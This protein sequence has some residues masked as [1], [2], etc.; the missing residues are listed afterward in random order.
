MEAVPGLP[1]DSQELKAAARLIDTEA[2]EK[3]EIRYRQRLTAVLDA[4]REVSSSL[5]RDVIL[6]NIVKRVRDL[7][8]V[9]EAVLFLAHEDGETLTP[10]VA[11]VD[12]FYE[13]V[14]APGSARETHRG[15]CQDRQVGDRE[16]RQKDSRPL[17]AG[18]PSSRPRRP[19]RSSRTAAGVLALSQSAVT[20]SERRSEL[21]TIFAGHCSAAI[22]NARA[23][24]RARGTIESQ[25]RQ[26]VQ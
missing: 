5:D 12:S 16:P 10:V 8:A 14:M 6:Q 7:V 26:L 17:S 13:E 21:A 11:H 20:T 3:R 15:L 24:H 2:L 18:T 1:P 23:P 4:S 25:G 19:R 9:P 22:E